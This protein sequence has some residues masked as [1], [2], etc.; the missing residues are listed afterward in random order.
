MVTQQLLD[1][2]E[3]LVARSRPSLLP[4]PYRALIHGEDG[5]WLP[6][7]PP[8]PSHVPPLH[9]AVRQGAPEPWDQRAISITSG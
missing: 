9:L 4:V 1:P 2:R 6:L 5:G 7:R 3:I 8:P